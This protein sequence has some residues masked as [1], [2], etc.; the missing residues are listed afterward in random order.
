MNEIDKTS[1]SDRT[2][3]KLDEVEKIQNYFNSEI[4]RRKL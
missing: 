2:K 3:F 1:F 4:D